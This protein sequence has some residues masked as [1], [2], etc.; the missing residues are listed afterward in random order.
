MNVIEAIQFEKEYQSG[1]QASTDLHA[2]GIFFCVP[3]REIMIFFQD[4][5]VVFKKKVIENFRPMD[6]QLEIDEINNFYMKGTYQLSSKKYIR[7]EFE[8]L[9]M[10]GLALEIN[11]DILT[12]HCY[13]KSGGPQKGK[14]FQLAK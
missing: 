11:R 7:C 4:G 14:A 12:F 6:G 2:G 8:N 10:V 3:Y 5:S 13:F 1:P 9:V